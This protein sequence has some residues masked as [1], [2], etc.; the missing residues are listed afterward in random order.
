[1]K[2]IP[3]TKLLV[4]LHLNP[5]ESAN[6]SVFDISKKSQI[7]EIYSLGEVSGERI[8]IFL[9]S[10]LNNYIFS[11]GT[12]YDITYNSRRGILGAITL[13]REIS[14]HLFNVDSNAS[15]TKDIVKLIRKSKWHSQHSNHQSWLIHRIY[16]TL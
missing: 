6:M 8:I 14:Y 11:L 15:K 1:M 9:P 2:E 16:F 4:S 3:N 7:K 5:R 12:G 13:G 10:C